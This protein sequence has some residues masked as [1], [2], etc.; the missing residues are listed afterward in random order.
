MWA[1]SWYRDSADI[2]LGFTAWLH[3]VTKLL[4]LNFGQGA[5]VRSP[6]FPLSVRS[7]KE[8]TKKEKC[9]SLVILQIPIKKFGFFVCLDC[10]CRSIMKYLCFAFCWLFI[11]QPFL[12]PPQE[13]STHISMYHFRLKAG[14][15]VII[16][17]RIFQMLTFFF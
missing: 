14:F 1:I 8:K 4:H 6:Y 17:K 3:M 2:M 13:G 15:N 11:M 7:N 9:L 5:L 10:C 16:C 12:V